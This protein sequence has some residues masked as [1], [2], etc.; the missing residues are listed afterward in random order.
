MDTVIKALVNVLSLLFSHVD[1]PAYSNGLKDGSLPGL[2]VDRARMPLGIQSLV[3]RS[4]REVTHAEEWKQKLITY[5]LEDCAA[6]KQVSEFL[7]T[8]CAL[9]APSTHAKARRPEV[10]RL[11]HGWRN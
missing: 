10:S 6:L 7:S 5:N 3:W 2:L 9:P 8:C 1:F 11:S 4:R